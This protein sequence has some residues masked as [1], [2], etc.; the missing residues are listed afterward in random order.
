M[1]SE[2]TLVQPLTDYWLLPS[3]YSYEFTPFYPD[4]CK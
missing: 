2:N 1:M 4:F 3:L